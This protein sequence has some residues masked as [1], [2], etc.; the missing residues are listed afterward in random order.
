[1][2]QIRKRSLPYLAHW[3]TKKASLHLRLTRIW[4]PNRYLKRSITKI[5]VHWFL[6]YSRMKGNINWSCSCKNKIDI[7][8]EKSKLNLICKFELNQH[9]FFFLDM[10]V[11]S[12]FA[13]YCFGQCIDEVN[14]ENWPN[15]LMFIIFCQYFTKIINILI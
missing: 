11:E 1:M 9:T 3:V 7:L 5:K 13:F 10:A 14:E 2:C 15:M 8:Q 12:F 4:F 6:F